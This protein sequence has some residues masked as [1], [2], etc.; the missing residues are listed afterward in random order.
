MDVSSRQANDRDLPDFRNNFA[1]LFFDPN[2]G[3]TRYRTGNGF[4]YMGELQRVWSQLGL[5]TSTAKDSRRTIV[6]TLVSSSAPIQTST[7]SSFATT[8]IPIPRRRSSRIT[9]TPLTTSITTGRAGCMRG[10]ARTSSSCSC[11]ATV[12]SGFGGNP[13]TSVCSITSLDQ[14]A[15]QNLCNPFCGCRNKCPRS[16]VESNERS[17]DKQHLSFYAGSNYSKK[18]QLN[19]QVTHRWGHFDFDFGNGDKYPRVSPAA[20]AAVGPE[21]AARSRSRQPASVQRR[22]LL[23]SRQTNCARQ[24]S[25]NSQR[26]RRYDTDRVALQDQYPDAARHLSVHESDVRAA[27]SRLQ[28]AQLALAIAGVVW[29]DAEPG[30]GVLRRLQRRSELRQPGIRLHEI[31]CPVSAAT[32]DQDASSSRCRT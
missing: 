21:S 6:L 30:H 14:H 8:R 28:H 19:G 16:T 13:V 3:E 32:R 12:G 15:K 31:S 22:A 10:K 1:Q 24:F 11:R 7:R 18:I 27:D 29:L 20:C 25:I 4:G 2:D 26:L 23:I 17:S 5:G 9:G